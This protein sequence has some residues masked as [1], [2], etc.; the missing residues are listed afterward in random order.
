K[1]M[2]FALGAADYF[3]KPIDFQRLHHVLEKYR[4]P[5]ASQTVLVIEDD[6]SMRDMLRR[7][8]E[9][10]GW[11]VAEAQNG[12]VGLEKLDGQVPALILLDLMMP[13]MDGF[14][15]MDALRRREAGKHLPVIVIT[16]K[17]LTE[18][19]HRR[20]NGGVERIIQKGA[21]SQNEVLKLV[22]AFMAGKIDYEL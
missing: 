5:T 20:L 10:D 22:R 13:E 11:Q 4:K 15:F 18:E 21:T 12:R 17:D 8:L 7:T 9:K 14:E 19:D 1:Q 3:T 16:A 2:G 6:V